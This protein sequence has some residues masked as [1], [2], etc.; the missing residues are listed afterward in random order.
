LSA[1]CVPLVGCAVYAFLHINLFHLCHDIYIYIYI[2]ISHLSSW[3]AKASFMSMTSFFFKRGSSLL[4]EWTTVRWIRGYQ[5]T[6]F[7]F[8]KPATNSWCHSSQKQTK[9]WACLP[10]TRKKWNFFLP[11]AFSHW[12]SWFSSPLVPHF[13]EHR[14][15]I[16]LIY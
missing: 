16:Y 1:C 8:N 10:L 2:Y 6:C 13:H 14:Y 9:K 3:G 4:V 5:L 12:L 15:L 7:N 11:I